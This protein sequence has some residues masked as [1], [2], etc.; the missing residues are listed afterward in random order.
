MLKTTVEKGAA[1]KSCHHSTRSAKHAAT[2][3]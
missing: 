3:S 2:Q 1:V